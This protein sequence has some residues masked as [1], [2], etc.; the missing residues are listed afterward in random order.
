VDK[1]AVEAARKD[2]VQMVDLQLSMKELNTKLRE[3]VKIVL[4]PTCHSISNNTFFT[5]VNT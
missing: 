4:S 5:K 1:R 2:V 3:P